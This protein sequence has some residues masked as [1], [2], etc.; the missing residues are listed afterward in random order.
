MKRKSLA[1]AIVS[2]LLLTAAS[3]VAL[4][5]FGGDDSTQDVNV[6]RGGPRGGSCNCPAVWEPVV[7]RNAAG[8]RFYFSNACVAG[9]NGFTRCA[10]VTI[11]PQP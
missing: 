4:A 8:E 7:C 10:E 9:C 6:V 11:A 3:A 2:G 1:I 5:G